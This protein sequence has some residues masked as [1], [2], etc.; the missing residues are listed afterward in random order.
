[1]GTDAV[2]C[3]W[4]GVG[5]ADGGSANTVTVNEQGAL[6][7]SGRSFTVMSDP[8]PSTPAAATDRWSRDCGGEAVCCVAV[9]EP[10]G[11][12]LGQGRE[13]NYGWQS[14]TRNRSQERV[15]GAPR[16]HSALLCE[17]KEKPR[18]ARLL[19]RESP[20]SGPSEWPQQVAPASGR[21]TEALARTASSQAWFCAL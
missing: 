1:M 17:T 8:M 20:V 9:G 7:S 14:F 4:H 11:Q 2:V 3:F 13:R 16:R 5:N 6:E 19:V 18:R 15:G 12:G 10:P 21:G